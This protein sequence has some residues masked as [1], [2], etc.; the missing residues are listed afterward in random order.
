MNSPLTFVASEAYLD[1]LTRRL[2]SEGVVCI[3]HAV[4]PDSLARWRS[5]LAAHLEEQGQRYFSIIQPWQEEGSAYGELAKDSNFRSLLT[6]LTRRGI[7]GRQTDDDIYNVL[8]VIAGPDGKKNS[9]MFHYDASV[10]TVLIPLAIPEGK[11]EDAGD[12]VAYCN[13]RPVRGNSVVN[14]I[15]KAVFQNP[16]VRKIYSRRIEERSDDRNIFRLKPGNIYLFWGYR[17]LHANLGCKANSLRATL[18]FHHGDPHCGSV[19]TRSIKWSRTLR[20]RLNL[21]GARA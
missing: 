16:L 1:S 2:D 10:I 7:P 9:L 3:D 19:V 13:H 11:P 17:T 18:L 21:R 20:E 14:A 12:L 6:G 5:Q 8:R 4:E 15:D